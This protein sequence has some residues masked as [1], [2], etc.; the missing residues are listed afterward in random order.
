M[1]KRTFYA[2]LSRGLPNDVAHSLSS[3]F[4]LS[5]LQTKDISE[6]KS[7]GLSDSQV[8]RIT[9]TSRPPIPLRTLNQVLIK[10]KHC[11]VICR[12]MN[13]PIIIHHI[14]SWAVSR[15]HSEKNLVV[16]CLNC[17]SKVHSR[18]EIARNITPSELI[19]F[20][21][22]WEEQC[23]IED[24]TYL[25]S[26]TQ[27]SCS[28]WDWFNTT[29]I[30]ELVTNN[31]KYINTES[32]IFQQLSKKEMI[33]DDNF[34]N[35]G[36]MQ[37]LAKPSHFTDFGDGSLVV[38]YLNSIVYNI[39][40]DMRFFDVTPFLVRRSNI[41]KNVIRIGQNIAF[42]GRFYFKDS[43]AGKREGYYKKKGVRIKFIYDPYYCAS[44]SSKYDSMAGNTS[45]TVFG[46]VIDITKDE[47]DVVH[48][49]LSCLVAG[50]HCELHKDR[51]YYIPE[52]EI[53]DLTDIE[54]IF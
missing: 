14:Q 43:D 49:S 50:S 18:N 11:C 24:T 38:Q 51:A 32:K 54:D 52:S 17:H 48:I 30:R 29:R 3:N 21:E 5:E 41:L 33:D 12:N 47:D 6:L 40:N 25:F 44:C 34:L 37:E 4:T 15:D 2:L 42:Q 26:L 53:D 10:S 9:K 46:R 45:L 19:K 13:N 27:K 16:L 20:K 8:D 28:R 36:K 35:M 22:S 31:P 1:S 39:I 7:F 23:L